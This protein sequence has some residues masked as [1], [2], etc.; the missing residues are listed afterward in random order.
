M[1]AIIFGAEKLI[2]DDDQVLY[3]APSL[4]GRLLRKASRRPGASHLIGVEIL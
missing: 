2:Q 4:N 3:R 1:S